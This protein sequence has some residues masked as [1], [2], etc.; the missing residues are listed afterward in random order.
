M[1][2]S[3]IGILS[4]CYGGELILSKRFKTPSHE[5]PENPIRFRV[6]R[7]RSWDEEG[8]ASTV[9]TILSLLVFLTFLGMFT[10]QYVPIWMKD[11]EN[12]HMNQVIGQMADLKSGIDMQVLNNNEQVASA[13]IYSPIK[14]SSEGVPVF[15]SPTAGTLTFI[16]D[17]PSAP[18]VTLTFDYT[19]GSGASINYYQLNSTNGGRVGGDLTFYGP[20]RY[21]IEQT[22]V[23]ENGAIILNQ[24]DG[25]TVLSGIAFRAVNYSGQLVLKITMT[26]LSGANKSI[27]G[28]GTKSITSTLEYTTYQK[29]ENSTGG[30]VAFNILTRY[31]SAWEKYFT[32]LK[33]KTAGGYGTEN[34]WVV[35]KTPVT[36][37]TE[38][39]FIVTV[40]IKGVDVLEYTKAVATIT[41]ADIGV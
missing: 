22:V 6:K 23:Y 14:L 19:T 16:S 2:C 12:N 18:Y 10:N 27:G 9:G 29:L 20:N 8:V 33:D 40:T 28:F 37:D 4:C 15:A 35:T 3:R 26:G 21:F 11:N 39:Y 1:S 36:V 34:A 32:D 24:T 5:A 31:G 38:A 25:E 41:I 17:N 7:K 13:P 30:T